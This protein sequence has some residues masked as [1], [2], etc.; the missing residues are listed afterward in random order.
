MYPLKMKP[1]LKHYVW[2]GQQLAKA[3]HKAP[4]S[5]LPIAE[6][7]E[8]S[9][10]HDGLSIIA[11]GP[12]AGQTL[13]ELLDQHPQWISPGSQSA[14]DFPIMLK[15]LD[16]QQTLSLQVHPDDHYAAKY[17]KQSGKDELWYI[18]D[19]KPGSLMR[20]GLS[21][22]HTK[23]SLCQCILSETVL[24]SIEEFPVYKGDCIS[25]PPGVL[26]SIGAGILL[27]EL[28][29]SSN[30]TY[31]VSDYDRR[32][33][34]GQKRPLHIEK[35]MDVVRPDLEVIRHARGADVSLSPK[36]NAQVLANWR[37]L[38][39]SNLSIEGQAQLHCAEQS[40]QIF[41]L[42][43][44]EIDLCYRENNE[45][46]RLPIMPLE[47]VFIPAGLGDFQLKGKG[48]GLWIHKA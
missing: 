14:D 25:V 26:H 32:D 46:K 41:L 30:I 27:A 40:F 36:E 18:I 23:E 48:Q 29:Q 47:S 20:A 22:P 28:Q 39:L 42:L 19:T 11:N 4:K 21:K 38:T 17:E 24:D 12:F 37:G 34:S 45:G 16:A 35:A 10:H 31:R 15:I 5:E 33:S 1:A 9:C 44:G 6:S 8:V 43:N 13:R 2:G 7:W 3:Y